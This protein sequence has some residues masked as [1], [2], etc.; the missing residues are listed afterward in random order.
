MILVIVESLS[1][2]TFNKEI[3]GIKI[4][5]FLDSISAASDVVFFPNIVTQV[6][7]GMSSDGQLMYNTGLYPL[8]RGVASTSSVLPKVNSLATCLK[9]KENDI[10]VELIGENELVWNHVSTNHSWGYDALYANL[11]SIK[12]CGMVD[13]KCADHQIFSKAKELLLTQAQPSL[14][15]IC[16]ISMHGPFDESDTGRFKNCVDRYGVSHCAFWEMTRRFDEEFSKFYE[17]LQESGLFDNTVI[18]VVSDHTPHGAIMPDCKSNTI[19]LLILNSGITYKKTVVAGQIDVYPTIIDAMGYY[20]DCEWRGFGHSLFRSQKGIVGYTQIGGWYGVGQEK[21]SVE[22]ARIKMG[23]YLS[24][25]ILTG[26]NGD[27][28]EQYREKIK[29]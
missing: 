15:T 13:L 11:A 6:K 4:T 24:E 18:V 23:H 19:P 27:F 28:S 10:A 9:R 1:S 20:D 3:A 5:P 21:D 26:T 17:F 2:T 8:S 12:P 16:T 25:K 22:I 29:W 7:A 14:M